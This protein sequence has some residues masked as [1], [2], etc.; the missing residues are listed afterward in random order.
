MEIFKKSGKLFL[1][2]VCAGIMCCFTYLSFNVI[3]NFAFTEQAG[4]DVVFD[5]LFHFNLLSAAQTAAQ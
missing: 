5:F 3:F 4:Y 2:L 1:Y